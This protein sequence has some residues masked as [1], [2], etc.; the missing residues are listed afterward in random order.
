MKRAFTIIGFLYV[1]FAILTA[2]AALDRLKASPEEHILYGADAREVQPTPRDWQ[3]M[4]YVDTPTYANVK[5]EYRVEVWVRTGPPCHWCIKWKRKELP[6]LKKAQ[7]AV[8]IRDGS[9]EEPPKDLKTYPTIKVYRRSKCIRT[10][11][12][13]TKAEKILEEVKTRVVLLR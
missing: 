5:G 11:N 1:S 2:Y 3:P 4:D 12:G 9:L 6:K 10:F 13:Y 8:K 7:V